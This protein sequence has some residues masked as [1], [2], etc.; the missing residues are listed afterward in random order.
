MSSRNSQRK[1]ALKTRT[2]TKQTPALSG[3][4]ISKM[5]TSLIREKEKEIISI[6]QI[7]SA[8]RIISTQ[9]GYCERLKKK[10]QDRNVSYFQKSASIEQK[11]NEISEPY[12]NLT[13]AESKLNQEI[14]SKSELNETIQTL[15][16]QISQLSTELD[17]LYL[18]QSLDPS[19]VANYQRI[20]NDVSALKRDI[21]NRKAKI[22]EMN[23]RK[24][25]AEARE[26][27]LETEQSKLHEQYNQLSDKSN[28]IDERA[29]K[30]TRILSQP[31]NMFEDEEEYIINLENSNDAILSQ[32]SNDPC[33]GIEDE[34]Q[35]AE[36]ECSDFEALV[37]ARK[38]ESQTKAQKLQRFRRSRLNAS[39]SK[40]ISAMS[41]R[42]SQKEAARQFLESVFQKLQ[43]R[44]EALSK[45]EIRISSR[46]EEN[47]Q[48]REPIILKYQEKM[49]K[50]SALQ[51][52]LFGYEDLQASI[53][54]A[55]EKLA[56]LQID[57]MNLKT[58][59]ERLQ[60]KCNFSEFLRK[61]IEED[62]NLI[63]QKEALLKNKSGKIESTEKEIAEKKIAL[64]KIKQE[65]QSTSDEQE[66][67]ENNVISIEQEVACVFAQYEEKLNEISMLI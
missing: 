22:D 21:D 14:S 27:D 8:S 24:E 7:I 2:I 31:C 26:K 32:I 61:K 9:E 58:Q 35:R 49:N 17:S 18:E 63:K 39:R 50:I 47:K 29:S 16:T 33:S 40:S 44:Q 12:K 57:E 20:S 52:R 45:E 67:V 48:I 36:K 1:S 54:K 13:S 42:I 23:K 53:S 41:Q 37:F 3:E 64:Q 56:D 62:S 30:A 15:Q 55:H 6:N 59:K 60:R 4:I 43:I 19:V 5:E 34:I 46:E 28:Q 65:V 38:E 25:E 10:L 51:E 66:A 11:R